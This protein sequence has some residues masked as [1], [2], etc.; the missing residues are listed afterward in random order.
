MANSHIC[1]DKA[2]KL[3]NHRSFRGKPA[4]LHALK[5]IEGLKHKTLRGLLPLP[6]ISEAMYYKTVL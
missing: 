5:T 2:Q 1:G 3:V 4:G 6:F